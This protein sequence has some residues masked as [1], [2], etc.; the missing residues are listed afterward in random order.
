MQQ[1][2]PPRA[3]RP[4]RRGDPDHETKARTVWQR[5]RAALLAG[6]LGLLAATSAQ[7]QFVSTYAY[8]VTTTTYT[9]ISGT[10]TAI[11]TT[12][13]NNDGTSAEQPIGFTLTFGGN[14]YTRFMLNSNG[15]IK[16][17]TA[18]MT[19][20][21]SDA[22]FGTRTTTT[23]GVFTS[24]NT[25]DQAII[26]ATNTNWTGGTFHRLT[27]G[28]AGSQVTTIQFAG[29]SDNWGTQQY[30]NAN[31]QIILTEG[32][33]VV[34]I[35]HGT[36]TQSTANTTA[37]FIASSA[38]LK[39]ASGNV[40]ALSKAS[41]TV[42]NTASVTVTTTTTTTW[43]FTRSTVPVSGTT[44]TFT[45]P[46]GSPLTIGT[47]T[48]VQPFTTNV[49]TGSVDNP[50]LRVVVPITGNAGTLTLNS[51]TVT[52]PNN[53]ATVSG[54]KLWYST[55]ATFA[56]GTATQLGTT[57][58]ISGG[59][60][61]FA[62]LSQQFT[63]A[64]SYL[65]VTFNIAG[66]AT[67]GQTVDAS[68]TSGDIII[69][70][71]AG[72]A[73][74]G[75][76]PN[77][78]LNPTGTRT[79]DYCT[80]S[81]SSATSS[82]IGRVR[83]AGIDN[84]PANNLTPISNSSAT[85]QYSNFTNL[86]GT[87]RQGEPYLLTVNIITSLATVST[88]YV[89]AYIDLNQNGSF[90]DAG[91]FLFDE[92]V[93]TTA[94][95]TVASRQAQAVIQIPATATL[96]T[97]RMRIVAS[98]T[99][100]LGPCSTYTSG[101]TE[102]YT[103]N[104]LA[105]PTCTAV[106]GV[107][108]NNVSG[109]TG[110][111][112]F[113]LGTG[114]GTVEV[115][116]GPAGFTPGAGTVVG[117]LSGSSYTITG[118]AA[119][120]S[121]DVYVRRDCGGTT[122]ASI[123]PIGFT[124]S[125]APMDYAVT[126][127]TG[128]T[129]NSIRGASAA[130]PFSGTSIDLQLSDAMLFSNTTLFPSGFAFH[131]PSNGTAGSG[132]LVTGM[133]V[134]TNGFI[135]LDPSVT[136]TGETNDFDLTTTPMVIAPLWD[137]LDGLSLDSIRYS[138]M[139]SPGAQT[140]T[141]E[142][143][144]WQRDFVTN[145][146]L[147][148]Q[149]KLHEGTDRIEF[150]YGLM[151]QFDGAGNGSTAYNYSL[152][153]TG[154]PT[155]EI[156]AQQTENTANFANL[157]N[158]A[159]K[160]LPVCNSMIS[161]VPG[162]YTPVTL[163]VAGAPVNDNCSGA[164]Q[165]NVAAD[166]STEFCT[167]YS[168]AEAT[169]STGITACSAATPGTPD[170]DVWFAFT[171][172]AGA[173]RNITVVV[174]G[175]QGYN[176]IVQLF[177]GSCGSL[178]A[179]NCQNVTTTTGSAE[180][181]IA[182]ALTGGATYYVRVY[183]S[184]VGFGTAST[185]F[186]GFVIDVYESPDPPV[187]DDCANAV[188]LTPNATC[189]NIVS[190]TTRGAVASPLQTVCSG[191]TEDD[192]WYKF[193]A[194]T[195]GVEI[196][197]EGLGT[198]NAVLELSS[199]TCSSLTPI[200]CSNSTTTGIESLIRTDLTVGTTYY[201]RVFSLG[202]LLRDRGNFNICIRSFTALANDDC[203]SAILLPANATCVTTNGTTVNATGSNPTLTLC[204]ITAVD[205]DVWY[206]FV[207][208]AS[209]AVRV[210]TTTTTFNQATQLFSGACGSLANVVCV[211]G[212]TGAGTEILTRINLVSGDTYYVRVHGA[213]TGE[214][215]GAFT[216]CIQALSTPANDEP[217]N[218]V[219]LAVGPT[220]C[221]TPTAGTTVLATATPNVAVCN[222][223]LAG[224]P[225]DDV[226]Y[227][228]TPAIANPSITVEQ[229]VSFDAVV[230]L[231]REDPMNP[232]SFLTV[233]C[234]DANTSGQEQLDANGLTIGQLYYIRVYGYGLRTTAGSSGDFTICVSQQ[235]KTLAA[236]PRTATQASTAV[237]PLG[238]ANAPILRIQLV[239]VGGVGSLPLQAVTFRSGNTSNADLVNNGVKLWI[240]D[241][242]TFD[243][244]TSTLLTSGNFNGSGDAV[245]S[246]LNYD[247]PSGT[248]YLFLTYSIK[249]T[250][251]V[252]N[253]L[254]AQVLPNAITV[255]GTNY[256]LTTSNP[257]GVRLIAPA[258]PANDEICGASTLTVSNNTLPVFQQFTNATA[259][260]VRAAGSCQ[261]SGSS[262]DVWFKL[263]VPST[264]ILAIQT[265]A[266]LTG[267]PLTDTNLL[268]YTSS[269]NTCSGT[270]TEVACD[271]DSY[272][273]TTNSFLSGLY[274][275]GLT[276]GAT[277]FLRVA[278]F[279]SSGAGG[280][281]RVAVASR[282][283]FTGEVSSV[284][285]NAANYFP[286]LTAT[287]S[288]LSSHTFGE[289]IANYV[290]TVPAGLT[291]N[292]VVSASQSLYGFDIRSGATLSITGTSTL[293]INGALLNSGTLISSATTALALGTSGAQPTTLTTI[294]ET[295]I[296]NL[297]IGNSGV[298]F[299]GPRA[300]Q[301]RRMLTLDGQL[302]TNGNALLL[303]SDAAGTAMVVNNVGGAVVGNATV[304][305]Y[306]ESSANPGLG[307]R[308]FS[309][310]VTNTTV[311]DFNIG[312]GS[313]R[314]APVVNPTYNAAA[315]PTV[316]GLVVPYPNVFDYDESRVNPAF[317]VF[318]RGYRSPSALSDPLVPGRGYTAYIRGG[319]KPDFVGTLGNGD[320]TVNVQNTSGLSTSGWNFLG[321]PY[322]SP[323]DW[324]LLPTAS[325]T[326]AGLNTQVSVFRS[327]QP[328]S[329]PGALD[330]TYLT[331]A[332]GMGSLTDGL[333]PSAQG[334]FVNRPTTG[335]GSLTM[336]NALRPTT[337]V[338]PLHFR[339]A[340][341]PRPMVEV[342]LHQSGR[343]ASDLTT[344]YFEAGATP[345]ADLLFDGYKLRSTGT[346]PSVFSRTPNGDDLAINGLPSLDPTVTTVVPLGVEVLVTG[347]YK[348]DLTRIAN[349]PAGVQVVLRDAVTGTDQDLTLNP[350]YAFTMDA[351]FR[352]PRFALVFGPANGPTGTAAN[353][354]SASVTVYPNPVNRTAELRVALAGLPATAGTAVQ[355][356]LLD[357]LGRV[358]RR[359]TLAVRG[360]A[361]DGSLPMTGLSAGVY[362]LQLQAGTATVVRRVVVE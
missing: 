60:A 246:G 136:N 273:G 185:T 123:G 299:Q 38:G 50:V 172:P 45:P 12:P 114:G 274:V 305:R 343:A 129:Y 173:P 357:N 108:I 311:A 31:F 206:K 32:S 105:P 355:A 278:R 27:T 359:A 351:T 254:D 52:T 200:S 315:D 101:E 26:S 58:T 313:P 307:Y 112:N 64:T 195:T 184:G 329:V 109:S 126:R 208:P 336:T 137:D 19:G 145:S 163:P 300:V 260:G 131:Y 251:T 95:V 269:N 61:T 146:N 83:V 37:S 322:P 266:G 115:E 204:G 135:T 214:P 170:D 75:G 120:T 298:T 91:E 341:D 183:E 253:T 11:T 150:V 276:P 4:A 234:V 154:N 340:T 261:T 124:T 263:N 179:I 117:G 290:I 284:T 149:V 252:G 127:T 271:E 134:S 256:A 164:I 339:P 20:P 156:T 81:A 220:G 10:G 175:A 352:G 34:Q 283:V 74:P 76:Q 218:A 221:A 65:H 1:L 143:M 139:G 190:G 48:G 286:Y 180:A 177:S 362:S 71:D 226:W 242:T 303:M 333:I 259:T 158:D 89:R 171:V 17:G 68:I 201:V 304:Q 317:P 132:P 328:F 151:S 321:N 293:T 152:G 29:M 189:S 194:T 14:S 223:S 358:V 361:A 72:A 94:P 73:A 160:R 178:T 80:S 330:G 227:K 133:K 141:I 62:G 327:E 215:S 110:Q 248:S 230:Q 233:D 310:P 212:T 168:S 9:D 219:T 207:A 166:P 191:T 297:T 28:T 244:A 193:V 69:T 56:T 15:F 229:N 250:A 232:G 289:M 199:G 77:A 53:S 209:G 291:N 249:A 236:T 318:E 210:T 186:G 353:L 113:S 155:T 100:G 8:A 216:I 325:L 272:G 312:V 225:D 345:Q 47:I 280:T 314:F 337:Y 86:I 116:Y 238:T 121:Y 294:V 275:N 59:T 196:S 142:W 63:L 148:F 66:T 332:N 128:I 79:V 165:L 348:L 192:V 324:D 301:V 255:N 282:P 281:F 349:I 237:V 22:L 103:V 87:I 287:S 147:N 2:F 247:L 169:A 302:T 239:V 104:V 111:V 96:G 187:N 70:A 90:N 57:Q 161:F 323:M 6:A 350:T 40:R 265:L 24:T 213:T 125:K 174:G 18:G 228:F 39:G 159:L 130:V 235:P 319:A 316:S 326:A 118:L 140:L 88:T 138:V 23:G 258:P 296:Q 92:N 167:L 285:T 54:V 55:S 144:S 205:D 267:T 245:F 288:T 82:D 85:G 182:P 320:V 331:R 162:T 67:V 7:A 157:A 277:V 98:T 102:D 93:G 344:V 231:V 308:H 257:T 36:W 119:T 334:F 211:N 240:S 13:N 49:E 176:P 46:A 203:A 264:G 217:A 268:L 78:D 107:S 30:Q 295:T 43:S 354:T 356:A 188:T 33:N 222:L 25:A 181:I 106:T 241:Q 347:A 338:N 84:A 3:P 279:G 35:K 335:T 44:Y 99:S 122:S 292:P 360:G 153:L 51:L 342:G 5:G 41:T 306:L 21:S 309:S 198:F 243:A 224:N 270:L 97:T 262:L 346:M 16:L 197:A 42:S 202:T